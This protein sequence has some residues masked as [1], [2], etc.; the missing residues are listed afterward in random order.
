M[1][2][3]DGSKKQRHCMLCNGI[4]RIRRNTND[5]NF[6]VSILDIYVII[7]GTAQSNK[8]DHHL[9]ELI[10]DESIDLIIYENTDNITALCKLICIRCKANTQV[11]LQHAPCRKHTGHQR[12]YIRHSAKQQDGFRHYISTIIPNSRND[13]PIRE[14]SEKSFSLIYLSCS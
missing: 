11:P 3:P 4:R 5:K 9:I 12:C 1:D 6:A 13:M 10:Y 7:S 8:T 14:R 2:T